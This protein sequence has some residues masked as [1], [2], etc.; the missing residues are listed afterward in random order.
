MHPVHGIIKGN[1]LLQTCVTSSVILTLQQSTFGALN[2]GI[3][4]HDYKQLPASKNKMFAL[5][6]QFVSTT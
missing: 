4:Q 5:G 1:T 6:N 2:D 3:Q